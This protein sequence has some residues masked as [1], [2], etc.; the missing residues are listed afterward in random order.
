M[1]SEVSVLTDEMTGSAGAPGA[2]GFGINSKL[3]RFYKDVRI[4]GVQ[5]SFLCT[6]ANGV[7]D[8]TVYMVIQQVTDKGQATNTFGGSFYY[9][10]VRVG[11]NVNNFCQIDVP[12]NT[13]VTII[14][15]CYFFAV[16]GS[17]TQGSVYIDILYK[18][19]SFL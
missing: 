13:D 14:G 18:V 2:W 7:W 12:A 9:W 15:S 3:I 8:A 11:S 4:V 1:W 5:S 19:K 10:S 16:S 17:P 6:D